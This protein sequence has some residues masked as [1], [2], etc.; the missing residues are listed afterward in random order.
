M[1]K[2]LTKE[3]LIFFLVCAKFSLTI[4]LNLFSFSFIYTNGKA[5]DQP[6]VNGSL[7]IEFIGD[8]YFN[9]TLH[10]YKFVDTFFPVCIQNKGGH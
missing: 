1:W 9:P 5:T 6:C 3:T 4:Y 8:K 10:M 7:N 2:Q